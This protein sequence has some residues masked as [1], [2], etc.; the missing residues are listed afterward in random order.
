MNDGPVRYF[1]TGA[2]SSL[3]A[4]YP[5]KASNFASEAFF[6]PSSGIA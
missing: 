4:R 1:D 6:S 2:P 3:A 5:L